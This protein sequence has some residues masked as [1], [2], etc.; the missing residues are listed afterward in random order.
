MYSQLSAKCWEWNCLWSLSFFRL[1]IIFVCAN[2]F[3]E[4]RRQKL[5]FLGKL[6]SQSHRAVKHFRMTFFS[7]RLHPFLILINEIE[8]NNTEHQEQKKGEI[9]SL[10]FLTFKWG[11]IEKFSPFLN[12][13]TS[14]VRRK[15]FRLSNLPGKVKF[16]W[17]F[18]L[19]SSYKLNWRSFNLIKFV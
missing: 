4:R 13:F 5:S 2:I 6:K 17:I 3:A 7:F 19:A 12:I 8:L 18:L 16:S 11:R 10:T 14:D 1:F 9:L 15:V